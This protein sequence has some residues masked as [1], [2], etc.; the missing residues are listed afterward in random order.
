MSIYLTYSICDMYPERDFVLKCDF[1]A[2]RILHLKYADVA[3]FLIGIFFVFCFMFKKY[4]SIK[5][6]ILSML[7]VHNL[8]GN[9][10]FA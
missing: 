10:K 9:N 1:A 6:K 7:P 8:R 3:Y 4:F 5:L 2:F